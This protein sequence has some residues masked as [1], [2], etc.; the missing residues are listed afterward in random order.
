SHSK[1]FDLKVVEY[2]IADNSAR[3]FWRMSRIAICL[4]SLLGTSRENSI[5]N[6]I[7]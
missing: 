2:N 4:K 7:L 6:E 5:S 1:D 3:D